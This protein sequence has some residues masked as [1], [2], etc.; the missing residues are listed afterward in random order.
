MVQ[1]RVM[2]L[3]MTDNKNTTE[4]SPLKAERQCSLYC[5]L[6]ANATA[7]PLS[8]TPIHIRMQNYCETVRSTLGHHCLQLIIEATP[9]HSKT[10]VLNV[11]E[12]SLAGLYHSG[13][14]RTSGPCISPLLNFWLV[15]SQL[16]VGD[17]S[18]FGCEF[19]TFGWWLPWENLSNLFWLYACNA[20]YTKG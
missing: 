10:E 11:E 19:S 16:L 14:W 20:L 13:F 3:E 17:F 4:S 8:T 7:N 9:A 2:K 18:T 15:T 12:A 6:R 5:P 1:T